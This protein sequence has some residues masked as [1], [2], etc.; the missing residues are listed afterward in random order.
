MLSTKDKIKEVCAFV[1]GGI[2]MLALIILPVVIVIY[3]WVDIIKSL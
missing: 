3:M 2:G 1:F